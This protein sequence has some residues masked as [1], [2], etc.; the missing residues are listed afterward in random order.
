[1]VKQR[2]LWASLGHGINILWETAIGAPTRR[3]QETA[4]ARLKARDL[5][6]DKSLNGNGILY[7]IGQSRLTALGGRGVVEVRSGVKSSDASQA[8]DD[9]EKKYFSYQYGKRYEDNNRQYP[10]RSGGRCKGVA[11]SRK[12]KGD[13]CQSQYR[14]ATNEHLEANGKGNDWRGPKNTFVGNGQ[15]LGK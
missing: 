12:G 5:Q 1:M 13:R 15:N 2:S 11:H 3:D 7:P 14:W 10:R 9:D 4:E 6:F 8:A